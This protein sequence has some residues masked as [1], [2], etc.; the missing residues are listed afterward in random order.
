M[1]L[2]EAIK[3][4]KELIDQEFNPFY[5]D[6]CRLGIEALKYVQDKGEDDLLLLPDETKK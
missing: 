6:A 5:E 2:E 1:T 3:Y 4:L